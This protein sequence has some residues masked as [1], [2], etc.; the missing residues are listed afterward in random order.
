M[1]FSKLARKVYFRVLKNGA[2]QRDRELLQ[3]YTLKSKDLISIFVVI[4]DLHIIDFVW[5]SLV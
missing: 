1:K 5:M 2:L 4:G 3:D